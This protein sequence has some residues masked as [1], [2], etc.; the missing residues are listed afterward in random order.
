MPFLKPIRTAAQIA[1]AFAALI[2]IFVALIFTGRVFGV[3]A[4][5]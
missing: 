2:F 1:V 4:F 5:V 3:A